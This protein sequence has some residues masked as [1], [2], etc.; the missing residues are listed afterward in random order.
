MINTSEDAQ[1]KSG[2]G[3]YTSGGGGG[4]RETLLRKQ[5][6]DSEDWVLNDDQAGIHPLE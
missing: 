6:W 4:G 1:E 2:G 5:L 3:A